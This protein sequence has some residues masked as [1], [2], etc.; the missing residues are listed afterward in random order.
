MANI[1]PFR[2]IR[3]NSIYADH[4]VFTT[5]QAE[6]VAGDLNKSGSL[7]PLKTLLETAA[8]QRPETPESQ[9]EAF[10]EINQ[11]LQNLLD[12]NR[13][14]QE[15]KPG[16]YIYEIAY[17]TYRQTGIWA[18][19]DLADYTNGDDF[20]NMLWGVK[21]IDSDDSYVQSAE[22]RSF[23]LERANKVYR[24]SFRVEKNESGCPVI[25]SEG[26]DYLIPVSLSHH[27]RFVGYSLVHPG[28]P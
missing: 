18:M 5:M 19:T 20:E 7:P 25:L 16:I 13:L 21:K 6:S 11:T 12:K 22:A 9:A 14:W 15:E 26:S 17:K 1:H 23:L 4:L 24:D 10:Q 2:A 8:R 28:S 3:P 27:G